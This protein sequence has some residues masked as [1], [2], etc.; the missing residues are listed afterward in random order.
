MG[1]TSIFEA[2]VAMTQES[3]MK[4]F[5]TFRLVSKGFNVDLSAKEKEYKEKLNNYWTRRKD[6]GPMS[7]GTHDVQILGN[8]AVMHIAGVITKRYDFWTWYFDGTSADMIRDAAIELSSMEE[9]DTVVLNVDSPGGSVLGVADAAEAVYQLGKKKKTISVA[10]S[11]MASAAYYIGSAAKKVYATPDA[12]VGSIGVYNAFLNFAGLLEKEGISYEVFRAGEYKHKP[13]SYEP[14][15]DKGRKSMQASVDAYYTQFVQ[16][17]SK[18]RKIDMNEALKMADGSVQIGT[19]AAETNMIDG[20]ASTEE[21]VEKAIKSESS[22]GSMGVFS[23]MFNRIKGESSTESNEDEGKDGDDNE[24]S[25]E[26]ND[27]N[28]QVEALAK[29]VADLQKTVQ[30]QNAT[31]QNQTAAIQGAALAAIKVENKHFIEGLKKEG[32]IRATSAAGFVAVLDYLASMGDDQAISFSSGDETVQTTAYEFLRSQLSASAPVVTL[33]EIAP[34][35]GESNASVA[36][37][38]ADRADIEDLKFLAQ[39]Y[40]D[41]EVAAGRRKPTLAAAIQ[42]VKGQAN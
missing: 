11:M 33:E 4:V 37:I 34:A 18:H 16:A 6:G 30:A 40:I 7:T 32:K 39:D 15:D 3:A 13:N 28:A 9:I 14:V 21:V 10:N 36:K 38:S 35:T 41:K 2:P 26:S 31:I 1:I 8:V 24:A 27:S 20:V 17:I 5:N 22:S 42:H 29:M 12:M 19:D 23:A 25:E